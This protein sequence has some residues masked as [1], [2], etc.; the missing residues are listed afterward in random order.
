MDRSGF[1]DN[2]RTAL[3]RRGLLI[4]SVSLLSGI[5]LHATLLTNSRGTD[6]KRSPAKNSQTAADAAVPSPADL[7]DTPVPTGPARIEHGAPAGFARTQQGAVAAAASFVC[8][9]QSLLD[10]DPL[11][12]EAAVR[13][14]ASAATADLQVTETLA[15]LAAARSTLAAGTGP[16]VYRQAAVAWRVDSYSPERVQVAVWSVGVLA[17][18]G[19][20]PPQAG[21]GVSIFDLVWERDDWKVLDERLTPGPA[22]ILDDSAAPATAD[23]LLASL[24]GFTDFGGVR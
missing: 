13:Q 2:G 21:W 17:R 5:A 9:G 16:V 12:A 19:V 22:P 15:K 11:A 18:H 4:A 3:G 23:Q 20:A 1:T 8:T 6:A 24:R 7:P 10:M 14:M